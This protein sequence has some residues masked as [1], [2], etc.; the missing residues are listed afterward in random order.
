MDGDGEYTDI[1]DRDVREEESITGGIVAKQ[2]RDCIG[3][4]QSEMGDDLTVVQESGGDRKDSEH[5]HQSK[6]GRLIDKL[7]KTKRKVCDE[8]H[9]RHP[10]AQQHRAKIQ[11]FRFKSNRKTDQ[12][13]TQNV[14]QHYSRER[15]DEVIVDGVFRADA[16]ANDEDRDADLADK[17]LTDKLF[18]L[19]SVFR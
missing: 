1:D 3:T 8:L 17:I 4:Y 13:E 2:K 15:T 19:R 7:I 9:D 14:P 12:A 16:N 5:R 6:G 11:I 18:K 10:A